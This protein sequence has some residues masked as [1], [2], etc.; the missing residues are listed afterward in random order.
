MDEILIPRKLNHTVNVGG[1]R[2]GGN[3]PVVVQSMTNTDTANVEATSSQILEL[4]EAGSEIV[5]ITVD[6]QA[7]ARA[8]PK[9]HH[10]LR[11]AGCDVPLVGDFHYNGHTL[12]RDVDDC[13]DA[14]DKYR[15]NPGNV[16][17]GQKR[18][19]RFCQMI[20][21]ACRRNKPVR[22]GVNW[23]S[24]DQQLLAQK[25]DENAATKQPHSLEAITREALVDSALSSAALAQ[26][27]GLEPSQIIL[28]AK[29]SRVSDLIHVYRELSRRSDLALHLGLTE[30][31]M[32]DKG[33]V[34]STAALAILM[35][36]GIGDTIR[37]SLTP[38][39]G[40][41][42]TREVRVAQTILQSL[43]L[44]SFSPQV[45]ACPGCGRTTSDFFQRLASEVQDHLQARMPHWR[46]RYPGVESL[47]VAV[48]G[49]IVNGPG[50]SR[51][52]DIGISLPGTGEQP[53]APVYQDG[54]KV[55]TLR[56]NDIAVQFVALVENYVQD[57][58]DSDTRVTRKVDKTTTG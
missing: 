25:L 38:Q 30:A 28:S 52:A 46:A 5:R 20:E 55:L 57:R 53:A 39:P 42:R 8:V 48:M 44:R 14:L 32:G 7:A 24:L 26:R 49:C 16:G 4:A 11:S 6:T 36:Q 54:K 40:E 13:A 29:V 9:I 33:V 31:G 43:G 3:F 37:V 50:E 27:E 58:F 2:I 23:G 18:D 22:I 1:I 45:T 10:R 15:I 19:T 51:H 17:K 12:L 34:S 56:G 35:H 21:Q 41:S 47:S